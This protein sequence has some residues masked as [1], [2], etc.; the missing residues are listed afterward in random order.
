MLRKI[1]PISI[2]QKYLSAHFIGPFVFST[3]FFVIFLLTFQ[4]FR[5]IRIVTSKGSDISMVLELMGHIAISFLPMAIPLSSLFAMI[6]TLNKL[7]EDSEVVAARSFGLKKSTLILPFFILSL[8]I[9]AM[10]FVLNRNLIP[11]SKTMF[12]NTIIQLTSEGNMTD[13]K[14]GQFF[15]EIPDI[16]LFAEEVSD[17]GVKLKEVFIL[18]KKPT[19]EHIIF[20]KRGALIKQSL[21][22]LRAPGMRLHLE[23]GNIVKFFEGKETEKILF[24]EY[25]FPVTSGG[26][27][28]GFVTKDSMRSNEELRK[29]ISDRKNDLKRLQK[30]ESEGKLSHHENIELHSIKNDLPKSEIEYWTRYNTPI[31]V[32][33]FIFLGFSLG[34][35][36]GR[37]KTKSSGS[38]GMIFLIGYYILFFGGVSLAR[39]GSVPAYMVVF[40]PTALTFL[41]GTKFYKNLDWQS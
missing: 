7:S 39:K 41:L 31:Q 28:P 17:G 29:V 5:I 19:G 36:R 9:A 32:I 38:L 24:K 34:I 21:G 2:I 23:E 20:A 14:S 13:I 30:L 11:H 1:L 18:Q 37:G 10:I 3:L 35:K 12:K 27:L 25:D 16:T 33:L 15:T 26:G 4:M 40:F 6:Y 8:L 22:E